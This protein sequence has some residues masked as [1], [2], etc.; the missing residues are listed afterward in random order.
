MNMG[1]FK[2][3]WILALSTIQRNTVFRLV[4]QKIP[5][6]LFLSR[7]LD[8][9]P[10]CLICSDIEDIFLFFFRCLPKFLF[11][12]HLIREFM[13]PDTT[14]DLIFSTFSNIRCLP[15]SRVEAYYLLVIALSEV[16]RAHWLFIFN[17]TPFVYTAVLQQT[18]W[19]V[20]R[21]LAERSFLY[22][23][24]KSSSSLFLLTTLSIILQNKFLFSFALP[25]NLLSYLN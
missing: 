9:P 23:S 13:W 16:W 15:S 11:W 24:A 8:S 10:S 7:S 1:S 17:D 4:F 3:F 25:P 12:D 2:R 14:I 18:R 5:T 21:H 6:R 22:E 19:Q 20:G